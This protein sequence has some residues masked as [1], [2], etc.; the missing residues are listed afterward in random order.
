MILAAL[1]LSAAAPQ[2]VT[3]IILDQREQCGIGR[4]AYDQRAQS[5]RKAR[6][7]KRELEAQGR[8]VRIVKLHPGTK[9]GDVPGPLVMNPAC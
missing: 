9:L 4:V 3:T 1:L 2:A 8:K 5:E 6:E 7:L